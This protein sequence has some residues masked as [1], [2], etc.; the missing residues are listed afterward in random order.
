QDTISTITTA[1]NSNPIFAPP[2]APSATPIEFGPPSTITSPDPYS[3]TNGTTITTDPTITSS[4][5]TDFGK[6]Y[7]GSAIDGSAS[8]WAFGSTSAF[9]TESGFDSHVTG[10]GAAFKFNSLVLTGDPTV[11]TAG[12]QTGLGLIAVNGITS[13]APGGLLTFAGINDLL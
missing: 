8:A 10:S 3:I 4:G 2:P 1:A 6:I 5:A 7:Q 12:G 11:S 9:D 13:G